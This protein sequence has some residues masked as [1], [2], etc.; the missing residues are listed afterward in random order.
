MEIY[1]YNTLTHSKEKF[2]PIDGKEIKIYSCGP[3][4]YS[5]AHIGNFRTY[6]FVDSLRRMFK[7][8]GKNLKHVMNITDCL[9]QT[10]R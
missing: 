9:G 3:T 10:K 7:Y 2:K 5:Y 8:N 6:V 1:L 4:V